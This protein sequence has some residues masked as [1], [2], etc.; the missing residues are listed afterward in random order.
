MSG[1][2]VAIS[3]WK[4]N[5]FLTKAKGSKIW[6]NSRP[7]LDFACGPGAANIGWNHP[8]VK[9][10]L[11]RVLDNNETGWGGN[12]ILNKYQEALA[13]ELCRITPGKYSKRVFFSNS[14]GEAVEAAILACIKR[15]RERRGIVSFTGD[16]HG[17]LGLSRTATTSRSMHFEGMPQA[18]E[19]FFPLIFPSEN[20]ETSAIKA[21]MDNFSTVKGYMGYVENQ[22]GPFVNEI[23]FALLELIQGEGG[24]NVAKKEILQALAAYLKV[25]KIL[26]IADEVQTGL[27]RTGRMWASELYEI[28]PDIIVTAKGLSGGGLEAIGATI[29]PE[30]LSY[31][32]FGEHCNT[33]GARPQSCAVGLKV[34][35]ILQ[36]ENLAQQAE[37]KGEFLRTRLR[38]IANISGRGLM[39]RI[40][41]GTPEMR[42]RMIIEA[43]KRGLYLTAA[44]WR[45]VRLMPPLTITYSE[46]KEAVEILKET[47]RRV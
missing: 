27:G 35:E 42:Q 4:P 13:L 29:M 1:D 25:N 10:T 31:Q 41:L 7:Y 47:L 21:F 45:S 43:G 19:R 38:G 33:F 22:I 28:E 36:R 24:I 44:G 30:E 15:R 16:F 46:L 12:M 6:L 32:E 9:K 34:L 23:N 20:P 3:C 18:M 17:R 40:T 11:K 5:L 37:E 8:E 26:I 14:G 2:C 39:N